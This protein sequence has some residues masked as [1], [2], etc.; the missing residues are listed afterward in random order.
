MYT[1]IGG[2]GK[3]YGPVTAAQVRSW[4]AAGRAN[5][6]T[7]VR[8]EGSDEWL[9]AADFPEIMATGPA[10]G[11]SSGARAGKLDLIS[12]YERSWTLL[13]ANFWPLVGTSLVISL[14]LGVVVWLQSL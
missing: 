4:I 12:C 8:A 6:Q 11:L 1:I 10:A 5:L 3:E 7:R 13:K 14:L 2:D 9:T